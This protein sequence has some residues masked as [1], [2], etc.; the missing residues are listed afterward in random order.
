MIEDP[1][2]P[3]TQRLML[4]VQRVAKPVPGIPSDTILRRWAEA[5]L[6]TSQDEVELVIRLVD[7]PES[8]RLNHAYRNKD[9]PTNILSFPFEA[10]SIVPVSLIGD[11][12]ICAPVVIREAEQLNLPLDAHWAH[13]VIHG[14]LHLQ[15]YDH[16]SNQQAQV[17]EER[18]RIILQNLHFPDPY[19]NEK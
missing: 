9:N 3:S 10:P 14:V 6:E 12:V 13:M 4:E 5:A 17:M 19:Q 11:L 1:E 16:Q 18:E 7:E 2:P 15:G 8:Q